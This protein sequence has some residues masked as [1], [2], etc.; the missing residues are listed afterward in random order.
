MNGLKIYSPIQN[1]SWHQ[2]VRSVMWRRWRQFSAGLSPPQTQTASP[3]LQ[4]VL[5]RFLDTV[6]APLLDIRD[7]LP[8]AAT[9]HQHQA[10]GRSRDTHT[11]DYI[12]ECNAHAHIVKPNERL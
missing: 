10:G 8:L 2:E 12:D 5:P 6:S 9:S 11:G 4:L 1:S 3:R 7:T